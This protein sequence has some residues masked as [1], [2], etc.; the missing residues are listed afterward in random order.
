MDNIALVHVDA[1]ELLGKYIDFEVSRGKIQSANFICFL[2]AGTPLTD[3]ST[4]QAK[5]L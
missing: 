3:G 5:Y 4:I 2:A 1:G